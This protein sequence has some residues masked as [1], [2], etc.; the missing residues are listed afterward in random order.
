MNTWSRAS[1]P[2]FESAVLCS[3]LAGSDIFFDIFF[4]VLTFMASFQAI[5]TKSPVI[6]HPP[7]IISFLTFLPKFTKDQIDPFIKSWILFQGTI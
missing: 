1:I 2:N 4:D 6:K 3:N 7:R 5:Y